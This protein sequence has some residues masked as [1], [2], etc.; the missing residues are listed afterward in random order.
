MSEFTEAVEKFLD[1]ARSVF[2]PQHKVNCTQ[3]RGIF[4]VG[5]TT[6]LKSK[7]TGRTARL[8]VVC[9]VAWRAK[10]GGKK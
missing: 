9:L 2:N 10:F 3:C 5:E 1:T 7:S 6:L 8:C 4:P